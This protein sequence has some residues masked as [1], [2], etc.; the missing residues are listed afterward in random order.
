MKT[1]FKMQNQAGAMQLA[2]KLVLLNK[3]FSVTYCENKVIVFE[4]ETDDSVKLLKL[5]SI[6]EG[7]DVVEN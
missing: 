4:A 1:V 6:L 7:R 2:A 3:T 5:A